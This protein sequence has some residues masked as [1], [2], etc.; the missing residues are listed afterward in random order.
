MEVLLD[1]IKVKERLRKEQGETETKELELS[2]KKY[3]LLQPILIQVIVDDVFGDYDLVVGERRFL[4]VVKLNKNGVEI[5]RLAKGTIHAELIHAVTKETALTMEFE[6]NERRKNLTWQEKAKYVRR[7]HD[8]YCKRYPSTWNQAMTAQLLGISVG[9]ISHHLNLS[10]AVKEH[11][12]VAKAETTRSAIKRA[13]TAR[14]LEVRKV[15]IKRDQPEILIR[16]KDMI[17]LGDAK[18]WI[19]TIPNNSVDLVNFDPPWGEDVS[20]KVQDNWEGFDDSSEKADDLIITLLPEIYRILKNDRFCIFW[21]RN[22]VY[23]SIVRLIES[24]GFSMKGSRN[25]CIWFK[26]DKTTDE[27]RFPE[28]MLIHAYEVFFLLRKGD[29]L[30]HSREHKINVFS[31]NRVPK[32]LKIHP[33]EKPVDLLQRLISLLTIPGELIIDPTAGSG[34]MLHAAHKSMRKSKGCDNKQ[35]NYDKITVRLTEAIAKDD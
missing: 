35:S 19:K 32:A 34:S 2:I 14:K 29:P 22:Q 4:A 9:M 27:M 25:P 6:E 1:N 23:E 3:G 8:M 10:Q 15:E 7:I 13:E 12:E 21:F 5:P 24:F 28:K 16:A 26:P 11:P 33:T 30:F 18:D 20:F 31:Y 17:H